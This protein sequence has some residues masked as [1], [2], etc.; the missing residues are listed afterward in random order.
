MPG[1][2]EEARA[3]EKRE[4]SNAADIAFDFCLD[5]WNPSA[6]LCQMAGEVILVRLPCGF[7]G[8]I[9]IRERDPGA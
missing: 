4:E 5:A 8:G 1:S 9:V 6:A 2:R 3:A 7:Y